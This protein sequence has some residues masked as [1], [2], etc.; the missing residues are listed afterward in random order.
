MK[1]TWRV[2]GIITNGGVKANI[3][4][5]ASEMVFSVRAP[6]NGELSILKDKVHKCFEAAATAT[7]AYHF[8]VRMVPDCKVLIGDCK[9]NRFTN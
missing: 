6:T 4:P 5:E 2:H 3:I 7:G 8:T 9:S 1:P